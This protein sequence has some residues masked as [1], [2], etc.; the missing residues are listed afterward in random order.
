MDREALKPQ[1]PRADAG[2][3][4]KAP[5]DDAPFPWMYNGDLDV[6]QRTRRATVIV[7][8]LNAPAQSGGQ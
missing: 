1:S 7:T 6:R 8:T 5:S 3:N 2:L 4:V